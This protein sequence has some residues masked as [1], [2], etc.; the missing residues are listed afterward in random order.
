MKKHQAVLAEINNHE[1]RISSVCQSG[2]HMIDENHFATDEI[3]RRVG[4]LNDHWNHLK[5]K[6]IQVLDSCVYLVIHSEITNIL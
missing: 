4:N 5:E 3:K 1:S 2:Q 6:A